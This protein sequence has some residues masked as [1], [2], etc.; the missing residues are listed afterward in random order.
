MIMS[1]VNMSELM[2]KVHE[3]GMKAFEEMDHKERWAFWT[4]VSVPPLRFVL[5]NAMSCEDKKLRYDHRDISLVLGY[6]LGMHKVAPIRD[7]MNS[8]SIR[9]AIVVLLDAMTGMKEMD[10]VMDDM[11]NIAA[12]TMN[13]IDNKILYYY[14]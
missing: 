10:A 2:K 3:K 11:V 8:Q 13:T 1:E 12:K 14:Q 7:L 5:R 6:V 4:A 9:L